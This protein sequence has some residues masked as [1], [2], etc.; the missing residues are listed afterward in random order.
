LARRFSVSLRILLRSRILSGVLRV[1][2]NL[3]ACT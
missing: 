1:Q 2:A 3:A